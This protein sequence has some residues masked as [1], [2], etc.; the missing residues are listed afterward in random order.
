MEKNEKSLHL[1]CPIFHDEQH[2]ANVLI[3]SDFHDHTL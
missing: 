2:N 1:V 3:N